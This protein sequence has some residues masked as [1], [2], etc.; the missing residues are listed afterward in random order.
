MFPVPI[1]D[2]MTIEGAEKRTIKGGD[3]GAED[4]E[5]L[6]GVMQF[7]QDTENPSAEM[8][9]FALLIKV[10][11]IDLRHLHLDPHFWLI[12]QGAPLHPHAFDLAFVSP[13]ASP[14]DPI[15]KGLQAIGE[16]LAAAWEEHG[17][18]NNP[19]AL[20]ARLSEMEALARQLQ[21]RVNTKGV[22]R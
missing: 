2:A 15:T 10:E 12:Q 5:A 3:T 1:P 21:L 14:D 11:P 18:T 6:V 17:D 7:G 9:F 16:R 8:P 19:I 13:E 4:V 20:A 22:S